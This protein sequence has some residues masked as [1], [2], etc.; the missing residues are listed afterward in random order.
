[1]ATQK[2]IIERVIERTEADEIH[3]TKKGEKDGMGTYRTIGGSGLSGQMDIIFEGE[4]IF[5]E[6]SDH[7]RFIIDIEVV[8]KDGLAILLDKVIEESLTNQVP[9]WLIEGLWPSVQAR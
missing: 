7:S 9:K 4:L 6:S 5:T 2:Q 8:E 3:W 1:M